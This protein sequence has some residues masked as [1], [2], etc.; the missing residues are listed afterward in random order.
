MVRVLR[1]PMIA[2]ALVACGALAACGAPPE[3]PATAPP[4]PTGP[5]PS[6]SLSLPPPVLTPIQPT[7]T[8]PGGLPTTTPAWPTLPATTTTP[9]YTPPV[10]PTTTIP[11]PAT[12]ATPGQ[13][14]APKCTA[15]PTAAQLIAVVEGTN[16]I[17][18]RPLKVVDGPF[19]SGSWQFSVMEIEAED[20]GDKFEPLAVVTKGQPAALQLVE[21][22]TDVCSLV[23][24]NEAPAGIRVR[25]CG[26]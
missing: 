11:T 16:G 10:T 7:Q 5:G 17:P 24:Q 2:G 20:A 12:P 18:D 22:G 6:A 8:T 26:A 19:C 25:A 1:L 3:P 21:A 9:V 23:V 13:S 4:L 15:G 14:S